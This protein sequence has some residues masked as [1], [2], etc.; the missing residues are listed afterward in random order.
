MLRF[1]CENTALLSTLSFLF[2]LFHARNQLEKNERAEEV[3]ILNPI[4]F[5]FMKLA[6]VATFPVRFVFQRMENEVPH[7]R[8]TLLSHSRA[9]AH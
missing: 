2:L 5:E 8:V 1:L 7:V 4:E 6:D 9:G 3:V